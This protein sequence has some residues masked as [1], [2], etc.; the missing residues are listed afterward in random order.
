MSEM[1]ASPNPL[2]GEIR[3]VVG[4]IQCTQD[5]SCC[6]EY[7]GLAMLTPKETGGGRAVY[8]IEIA[9]SVLCESGFSSSATVGYGCTIHFGFKPTAVNPVKPLG[10]PTNHYWITIQKVGNLRVNVYKNTVKIGE[11][12][13]AVPSTHAAS[14]SAVLTE[15]AG[16]DKGYYS[17]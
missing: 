2:A 8:P 7:G 11:F 4:A 16:T 15:F 1:L 13:G 17:D 3:V 6:A 5:H 10:D 12:S 9:Y 14:V